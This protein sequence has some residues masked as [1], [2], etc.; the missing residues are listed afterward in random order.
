MSTW[1]AVANFPIIVTLRI[2]LRPVAP[3]PQGKSLGFLSFNKVASSL[4]KL[5]VRAKKGMDQ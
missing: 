4:L 5:G 3:F 2:P 1:G